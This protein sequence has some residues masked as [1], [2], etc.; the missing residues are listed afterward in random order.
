MTGEKL[1]QIAIDGPAASGK[2][3]VAKLIATRLKAFYVNTG[4]MYRTIAWASLQEGLD[5]KDN[6]KDVAEALKRWTM[7]F[8]DAGNGAIDI[9]FN[10][11]VV[12][13]GDIRTPEVASVVSYV[14][15]IPEVRDWMLQ[16][17]RDCRFLGTVIME[18][19][20]IGT[21]VLPDATCKFFVTASPMERA[22]RRFLQPGEAGGASLEEVAAE[23][24]KRDFI[25]STRPVA[26]LKAAED[27]ITIITDGMSPDEVA[28]R[29]ISVFEEK[30]N[31]SGL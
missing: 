21:V 6:P 13:K 20:D 4:E 27:A 28:D 26:P 8:K 30:K 9:I 1:F 19:R 2:S 18:G 14:A 16:R 11:K 31:A 17:Q 15:W 25:D 5:P 12:Q 22:R 10:G 7:I 3:T 29:I 23:I 24:A